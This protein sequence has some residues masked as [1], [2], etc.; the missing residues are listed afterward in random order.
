MNEIRHTHR[1][2]QVRSDYELAAIHALLMMGCCGVVADPKSGPTPAEVERVESE[3]RGSDGFER[4]LRDVAD[5]LEG[6]RPGF[7]ALPHVCGGQLCTHDGAFETA[8]VKNA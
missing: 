5:W 7:V 2:H 6:F 3:F 8:I 4:T 1:T